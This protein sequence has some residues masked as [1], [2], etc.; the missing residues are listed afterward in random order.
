MS[1]KPV[2]AITPDL[3]AFFAAAKRHELVV[4]RCVQCAAYRFPP[5]ALCSVCLSTKAE[6]VPVSGEGEVFSYNVMHQVYHPGFAAEVP[7]AVVV[8]K[9]KEG[10]KM[11]SNLVGVKPHDIRIGM[12]VKVVFEDVSDAVTL[13]KFAPL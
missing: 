13:P 11:I 6:W 4:Q 7:Y 2:P 12:P 1:D 9:L 5:R 8:I 10:A 3:E